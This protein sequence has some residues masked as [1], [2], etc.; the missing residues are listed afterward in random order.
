MNKSSQLNSNMKTFGKILKEVKRTA[1]SAW[2]FVKGNAKAMIMLAGLGAGI[3]FMNETTPK[4]NAG[5]I[6]IKNWSTASVYKTEFNAKNIAGAT[7][8]YDGF[9]GSFLSG[10]GTPELQIYS[11]V[12]GN[13]L[14]TDAHPI[15]TSGWDF[16]LAVKGSVTNINNSL[17]Y[18]VI[19]ANGLVG[20]TITMYDKAEP[21]TQYTLIVDSNYHNI[22]LPSLTFANGEYA[23]WRLGIRLLCDWNEDGIVNFKD[24]SILALDWGNAQGQ[25]VGDISGPNEIPDGYVD[26]YDLSAFHDDYLK[27]VNDP[28]TW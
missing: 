20:K 24:F 13:K 8:G 22:P 21:N 28:N 3:Y 26:Y 5:I 6:N 7:E 23:H 14:S 12:E 17:W 9:D 16:D 11:Q 10:P 19:D 18:K 1:K 15:I 4:A 25:Y 27:D 2:K